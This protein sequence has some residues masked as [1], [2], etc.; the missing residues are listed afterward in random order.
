MLV[1]VA[2]VLLVDDDARYRTA[3]RA[4]LDASFDIDV[5]G[6]TG[7]ADEAVAL[8]ERLLPD[9]AV[10]DLAMPGTDGRAVAE[11]LL[12]AVP[13]LAVVVVSGNVWRVDRA[14]ADELGVGAV[15]EKGDPLPVENA[16]RTLTR[17]RN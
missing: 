5:V 12:A 8:A 6:D 13:E 16:L 2:T 4:F 7:D 17:R 3:L 9:A 15:L 14:R 1:G 11:R 10:I